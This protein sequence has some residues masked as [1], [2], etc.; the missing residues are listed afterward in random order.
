MG[1]VKNIK[2]KKSEGLSLSV[3]VIAAVVLLV[4]VVLTIIFSTRMGNFNKT[5]NNCDTVCVQNSNDCESEGYLIPVPMTN[6]KDNNNEIKGSSY[7]CKS[8]K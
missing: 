6:C 8:E 2:N 7:C 5:M 4:L 1:L 3:V